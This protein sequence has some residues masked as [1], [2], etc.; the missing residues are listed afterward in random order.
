[1]L[2]FGATLC[3]SCS[4]DERTAFLTTDEVCRELHISRWTLGRW[5]DSGKLNAKK[6]GRRVLIP[7]SEVERL[8]A[9]SNVVIARGLPA[10]PS[11]FTQVAPEVVSEGAELIARVLRKGHVE[12]N[13]EGLKPIITATEQPTP[14]FWN[15]LIMGLGRLLAPERHAT[16]PED[17]AAI[18]QMYEDWVKQG[19]QG[20]LWDPSTWDGKTDPNNENR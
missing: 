19:R 16:A 13:P 3:Y 8:L 17:Q 18:T 11:W 6:V 20:N 2:H 1:M 4:V 7:K 15:S 9:G 14:V 10:S 12:V 5:I